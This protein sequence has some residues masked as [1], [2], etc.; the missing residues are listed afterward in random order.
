VLAFD[1][2]TGTLLI[3]EIKTRLQ[4]LG[5]MERRLG[6]YERMAW[7]SALR[8]GWRPRRTIA[9]VLALASDEVELVVRSHRDVFRLAFP[10]RFAE[11]ARSI[12]Q[13]DLAFAGRGFA[14][15]DPTSRRR[16][17]II[18]TSLDGR[19]SRLPYRDHADAARRAAV[20]I[21]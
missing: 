3:V 20:S 1:Q 5:A 16:D 17:W 4:D 6:W 21:V 7:Q 2:R 18:G 13:P 8:L 10:S 14:L 9:C 11:L 19:R 15:I 12:R